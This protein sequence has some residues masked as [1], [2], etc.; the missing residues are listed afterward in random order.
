MKSTSSRREFLKT[1]SV[2]AAALGMTATSYGRVV[3]ANERIAIGQIGCGGRGRGCSHEGSQCSRQD[4][5]LR[6]YR[7]CRSLET[8][9]GSGLGAL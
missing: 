9:A 7:G 2:G 1:A 6:D 8:E 5:E 3:G 4:D